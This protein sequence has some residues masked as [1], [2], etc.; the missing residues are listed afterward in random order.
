M[1][2]ARHHEGLDAEAAKPRTTSLPHSFIEQMVD[3]GQVR[4]VDS[5]FALGYIRLFGIEEWEKQR[6]RAIKHPPEVNDKIDKDEL[7]E[8]RFSTMVEQFRQV[9]TCEYAEEWD[10]A[11]F[12]DGFEVAEGVA[13][14]QC[15]VSNGRTYCYTRLLMGVRYA[16]NIG[17]MAMELLAASATH[18]VGKEYRVTSQ[19]NIDNVRFAGDKVDVKKVTAAFNKIAEDANVKITQPEEHELA[20]W[21]ELKHK[22][23]GLEYDMSSRTVT[24]AAKST[25]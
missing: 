7:L 14:Y 17:Q 25:T 4:E 24:L 9:A 2:D 18:A 16:V 11:A 8:V 19:V 10:A 1:R 3:A 15:F 6:T 12:Y 20:R 21:T 13:R 22:W 23:L 5:R